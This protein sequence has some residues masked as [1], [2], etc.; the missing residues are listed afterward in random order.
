MQE[1]C[2]LIWT[3]CLVVPDSLSIPTP[4]HSL[5]HTP[6]LPAMRL[7]FIYNFSVFHSVLLITCVTASSSR[8]S[9]HPFIQQ[10]PGP[11]YRP[12]GICCSPT[13]G[14]DGNVMSAATYVLVH[15][16]CRT[17]DLWATSRRLM[18]LAGVFMRQPSERGF[19]RLVLVRGKV[20]LDC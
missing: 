13:F 4:S 6:R 20:T 11:P 19:C 10:A 5:A 17:S 2:K 12:A 7:F 16:L 15:N 18:F 1:A 8:Q 3:Q 14:Y 9:Q